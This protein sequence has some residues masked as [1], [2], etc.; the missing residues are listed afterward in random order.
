MN[1]KYDIRAYSCYDN[2]TFKTQ[3]KNISYIED[4]LI[5]ITAKVTEHYASDILFPIAA[6]Q[7][8][9]EDETPLDWILLFRDGGVNTYKIVD[10][11][12]DCGGEY[13]SG[14]QCWRLTHDPEETRTVLT[15]VYLSH[16]NSFVGMS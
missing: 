11:S 2:Y 10:G 16:P 9:V 8:A 13:V 5:R 15:R 14:I 6:L 4:K 3:T 1:I 12:P 7:R